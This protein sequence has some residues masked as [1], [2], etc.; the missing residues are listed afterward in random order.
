MATVAVQCENAS[1]QISHFSTRHSEG[2]KR[3]KNLF[4]ILFLELK[5]QFI[6]FFFV[7]APASQRKTEPK[8]KERRLG[9]MLA[10]SGA[11]GTIFALSDNSHFVL[12]QVLRANILPSAH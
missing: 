1:Q 5:F 12:K 11:L 9:L 2:V 8:E 6:F 7:Q 3:P 10:S 4:L